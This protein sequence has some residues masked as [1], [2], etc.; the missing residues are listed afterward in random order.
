MRSL[1]L[2]M[3]F[4]TIDWEKRY[5]D[6]YNISCS[7]EEYKERIISNKVAQIAYL[8]DMDENDE[9]IFLRKTCIIE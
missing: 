8:D 6:R 7:I 5:E 4:F 9:F 3:I 1:N 2:F